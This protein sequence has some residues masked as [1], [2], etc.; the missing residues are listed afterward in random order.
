LKKKGS[1]KTKPPPEKLPYKKTK[2]ESK[3]VAQKDLDAF[4]KTIKDACEARR[5]L[6]KP[7]FALPRQE[8]RR[9][10]TEC[11]KLLCERRKPSPLSDYECSLYKSY[12]AS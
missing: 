12:K 4:W 9:K 7:Q 6:Q 8:L 3:A 5:N 1:R 11:K 2:E 10:I